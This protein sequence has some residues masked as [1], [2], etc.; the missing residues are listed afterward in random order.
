M[1]TE[2]VIRWSTAGAVLGVAAVAAVASYEHASDLVRAHGESG[3]SA[4]MAPLTVDGLICASSMVMMDP[5]QGQAVEVFAEQ[6][7]ADRVPSICPTSPVSRRRPHK[8]SQGRYGTSERLDIP[9]EAPPPLRCQRPL[10]SPAAATAAHEGNA[11][12]RSRHEAGWAP[13]LASLRGRRP[14]RSHGT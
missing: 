10:R 3:W 1:T 2:R 9:E 5:R 4:R 12:I 13:C 14:W 6:L 11:V 8:K 7:A